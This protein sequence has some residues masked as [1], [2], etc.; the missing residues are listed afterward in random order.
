MLS[1][2]PT[3]RATDRVDRE[4][5]RR[6]DA[7]QRID[8]AKSGDLPEAQSRAD[9]SSREG[10]RRAG[11]PPATLPFD[12]HAHW[13]GGSFSFCARTRNS[14]PNRRR[15]Q[16]GAPLQDPNTIIKPCVPAHRLSRS[17]R[18]SLLLSHQLVAASLKPLKACGQSPMNLD[19]I[20]RLP[21]S[22]NGLCR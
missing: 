11:A 8:E 21:R 16:G 3:N 18:F 10:A 14:N 1:R 15:V 19:V 9:R 6:A 22:L 20:S 2:P 4:G 17:G 12:P 13:V 5:R 7:N